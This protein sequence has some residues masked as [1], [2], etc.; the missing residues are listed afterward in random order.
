M[1]VTAK[2]K[3]KFFG[4]SLIS[5][6]LGLVAYSAGALTYSYDSD[7]SRV[8]NNTV[9]RS[10]ASAVEFAG[11][12]AEDHYPLM[13]SFASNENFTMVLNMTSYDWGGLW[14][15]IW[16][17]TLRVS[18]VGES[19]LGVFNPSEGYANT[20]LSASLTSDAYDAAS[21]EGFFSLGDFIAD[22]YYHESHPE[23][24]T[25]LNIT[26]PGAFKTVVFEGNSIAG[27]MPRTTTVLG[28]IIWALRTNHSDLIN[29]SLG[30]SSVVVSG[31]VSAIHV[32][33]TNNYDVEVYH[34]AS[35]QPGNFVIVGSDGASSL[36][37]G[38]DWA[39]STWWS[40]GILPGE[41]I[42]LMFEFFGSEWNSSGLEPGSYSVVVYGAMNEDP[43]K[44]NTCIYDYILVEVSSP[45]PE[46]GSRIIF[47]GV[48]VVVMA[49]V[50]C[51]RRCP[52]KRP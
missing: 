37:S 10:G 27:M 18:S 50:V 23:R 1:G 25:E 15:G 16:E 9:I 35:A 24:L 8:S 38:L 39:I 3:S 34:A 36:D 49:V 28:N 22:P 2:L 5:L 52:G 20:T 7:G 47:L 48:I 44:Y 29:V 30:V 33:M 17:G 40:N 6:V 26:T 14:R 42:D 12:N 51:L 41:S 31:S 11:S 32:N 45:I 19:S 13:T 21:E 46:F 4:A 43:E